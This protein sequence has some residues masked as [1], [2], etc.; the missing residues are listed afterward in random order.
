M[1]A[2]ISLLV[3]C[4]ITYLP[5]THKNGYIMGGGGGGG[6]GGTIPMG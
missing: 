2:C 3:N 1:H 5:I 4:W 6:G